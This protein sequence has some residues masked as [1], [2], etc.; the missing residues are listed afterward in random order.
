MG[1]R[2]FI[3]VSL[4]GGVFLLANLFVVPGWLHERGLI[5]WARHVRAEFLT[6]TA[7]TVIVAL[8]ILLTGAAGGRG[9]MRRCGV[10]HRR[11]AG[12]A[13]YCSDCGG[14]V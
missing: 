4:V 7:I 1:I 8:L 2:K 12:G 14:R 11:I 3:V 6:G 9:L 5:D 10:C 13:Q